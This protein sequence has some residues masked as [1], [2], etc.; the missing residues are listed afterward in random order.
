MDL[1]SA[2]EALRHDLLTSGGANADVT[3]LPMTA[4]EWRSAARTIARAEGRTVR[5]FF[6]GTMLH[7]VLTDWPANAAEEAALAESV[8]RGVQAI[9]TPE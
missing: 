3:T 8:R 9:P 7:A 5:T 1:G 4:E 6:S 2:L